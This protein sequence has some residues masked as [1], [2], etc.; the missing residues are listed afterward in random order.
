[1]CVCVCMYVVYLDLKQ[2]YCRDLRDCQTYFPC[3]VFS[4]GFS[5]LY[6][7]KR[8]TNGQI[9]DET[10]QKCVKNTFNDPTCSLKQT[11]K[12]KKTRLTT[13]R[14]LNIKRTAKNS[15]QKNIKVPLRL[16][17]SRKTFNTDPSIEINQ[18]QIH[19][20]CYITNWSRYRKGDAKFQIEYI[21]PFMCSHIIYAYATVNDN[22]PEII[23]IQKDDIGKSKFLF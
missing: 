21:D 3:A 1:M 12:R 2:S 9:F 14:P 4:N 18:K 8:C 22:K 17:S 23:P 7:I 15:Q 19:R 13:I 20:V 10:N 11:F 6:V 16:P 5:Y